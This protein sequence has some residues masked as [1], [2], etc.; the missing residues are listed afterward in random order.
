[1]ASRDPKRSYRSGESQSNR[2][3]RMAA[4]SSSYEPRLTQI[5]QSSRSFSME[6]DRSV[7]PPFQ[8]NNDEPTCTVSPDIHHVPV[9]WE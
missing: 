8:T 9:V 7:S 4:E 6:G 5:D 1:M 3:G 2:D